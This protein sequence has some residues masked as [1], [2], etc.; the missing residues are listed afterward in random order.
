MDTRTGEILSSDSDCDSYEGRGNPLGIATHY[1]LNGPGIA[2]RWGLGAR[3]SAPVQ[4]GPGPYPAS[5]TMG[6]G[7]FP[8]GKRPGRGVDHPPPSS[9]EVKERVVLHLYFAL[10]LRGLFWGDLYL[11]FDPYNATQCSLLGGRR[12]CKEKL[13]YVNLKKETE[14]HPKVLC[15]FNILAPELFF[16]NF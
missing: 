14:I 13:I 4:T 5:C 10:G 12:I 3:F 11:Y 6:T 8:V 7:S 16:F 15:P 9:A 2:S 1:G